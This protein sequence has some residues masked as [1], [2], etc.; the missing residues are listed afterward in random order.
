LNRHHPAIY[1]SL[2]SYFSYLESLY[3][4]TRLSPIVSTLFL[5]ICVFSLCFRFFPVDF[6]TSQVA[7]FHSFFVF[8]LSTPCRYIPPPKSLS[9]IFPVGISSSGLYLSPSSTPVGPNVNETLIS[10][11]DSRS[12]DATN[13]Y[14]AAQHN[15]DPTVQH[16]HTWSHESPALSS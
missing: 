14:S 4:Y 1:L 5:L 9:F 12:L 13:H 6:L 10:L 11:I 16:L 3:N 8:F 7:L 2:Y 15:D